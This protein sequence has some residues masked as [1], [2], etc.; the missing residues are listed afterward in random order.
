M[1]MYQIWAGQDAPP[2]LLAIMP[3]DVLW[4]ALQLPSAARRRLELETQNNGA[5]RLFFNGRTRIEGFGDAVL[6]SRFDQTRLGYE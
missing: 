4:T 1:K 5:C 6:V 2:K 3:E